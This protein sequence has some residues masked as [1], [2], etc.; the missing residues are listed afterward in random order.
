MI[1]FNGL[2]LLSFDNVLKIFNNVGWIKAYETGIVDDEYLEHVLNFLINIRDINNQSLQRIT[3][4]GEN[5]DDELEID[6]KFVRLFKDLNWDIRVADHCGIKRI[7]ITKDIVEEKEDPI[8]SVDN[9]VKDIDITGKLEDLQL[10]MDI[11]CGFKECCKEDKEDKVEDEL[12]ERMDC[13]IH[14][15][16]IQILNCRN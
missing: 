16:D 15:I 3:I 2:Q 10:G 7:R 12:L 14:I 9:N 5:V 11:E 6:D 13:L 8:S 1:E 4:T